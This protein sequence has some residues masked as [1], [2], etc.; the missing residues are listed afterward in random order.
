MINTKSN[1]IFVK[2]FLSNDF[3]NVS[4]INVELST[5][6]YEKKNIKHIWKTEIR[7]TTEIF[8]YL[9]IPKKPQE[10]ENIVIKFE[11]SNSK[12][13]NLNKCII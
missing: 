5:S 9:F 12:N 2:L 1:N 7:I 10:Y 4:L 11:V 13:F 8:K 3:R 6:K